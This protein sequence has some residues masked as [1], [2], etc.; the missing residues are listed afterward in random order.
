M[1]SLSEEVIHTSLI[2]L[3]MVGYLAKKK[4]LIL[5]RYDGYFNKLA[6]GNVPRQ[7]SIGRENPFRYSRD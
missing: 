1:G 3:S 6:E 7:T 4:D 2:I 5:E